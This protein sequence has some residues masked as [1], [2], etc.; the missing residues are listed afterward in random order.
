[1]WV[2]A[3]ITKTPEVAG[4]LKKFFFLR[5]MFLSTTFMR[6]LLKRISSDHGG[7]FRVAFARHARARGSRAFAR[8]IRARASRACTCASRACRACAHC[9]YARPL[10]RRKSR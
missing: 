9:A 5:K 8:R 1:M 4:V 2:T 10:K 7:R 6:C 3:E